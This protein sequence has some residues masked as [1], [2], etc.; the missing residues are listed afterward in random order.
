MSTSRITVLSIVLLVAGFTAGCE[1]ASDSIAGT[2]VPELQLAKPGACPGHPSC[3]DSGD[4]GCIRPGQSTTVGGF[5]TPRLALFPTC[6][7]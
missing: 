5:P 1:A 2:E 7:C 4:G 6:A 3:Q